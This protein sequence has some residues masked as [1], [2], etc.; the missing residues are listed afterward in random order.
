MAVSWRD[1]PDAEFAVLGDPITHSLS[2]Q[3]HNAA[4]AELALPHRYVA[5]HT[6]L[7]ELEDALHHLQK[8]GYHGL[9]LTVPLKERVF[10]LLQSAEEPARRARA[11]NTLRLDGLAGTNTD[12]GGFLATLAPLGLREGDTALVLGAGG[13][14]RAVLVGLQQ[15]GLRVRLYNRTRARAER[16]IE[17][18]QVEATLLAQP[19]ATDVRLIVNATSAELAGG[20][21]VQ[22]DW[23]SAA[24][25]AAA[26]DLMYRRDGSPTAF[27]D[28]AAAAGL[29]TTDGLAMLVEQG[30]LAF[31]WWLGI[32]APREV[33]LRAC[34]EDRPGDN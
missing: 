34:H 15:L 12:V 8:R 30:A 32:E 3:M 21:P 16:L 29:K 11:A 10:G 25:G 31:E 26:Y 27:L 20:G 28:S 14:A 23:A 33:M 9:N 6:P 7:E 13:A 1:A 19:D 17:E 18:L 5:L 2:P 22:L 24:E 4:Y